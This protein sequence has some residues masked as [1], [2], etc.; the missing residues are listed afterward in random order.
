MTITPLP[1]KQEI[2]SRIARIAHALQENGI[3]AMLLSNFANLYYTT[4]RVFCGYIYITAKGTATHFVRRPVDLEG[5]N[6]QYIRK[7]EQ[8][9]ELLGSEMPSTVALELGL[10]SYNTIERL[11]N[12][13]AGAKVVDATPVINR[14]RA[15]KSEFEIEKLRTCG[16]HHVMAYS[17]IPKVYRSGMTDLELQI[18]VERVLRSEG[19][20]GQF[21]T[22]GD[23][24]EIF[25]GSIL[26][27]RN[28][29]T[30]T[31]YDFALG[32][33][34]LDESLPV[35]CNGSLITP[36]STVMVDMGGDFNGYMTDLTRVYRVGTIS[37]LAEHAHQVSIDIHRRLVAMAR[38][39]VEA[40]FLY[41][42]AVK[43]VT[44]EGLDD[45]F[46][47]TKQKA[48]FIGHGIGIE[49][50][51]LPVL[52]PR[53]H[54]KLVEG[55]VIAIEPKFVIPGVGGVGIENTYVVRPDGLECLTNAP[56]EIIE[57]Y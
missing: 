35:G 32:G 4:G 24:M 12:V 7:P 36:G 23:S 37:P 51:E 18:E 50:S 52:T 28:A 11:R 22:P 54:D 26:C 45:Y 42:E 33:S 34:G 16:I 25:M 57:L 3:D 56:E 29:E 31:P 5:D 55:N 13:F 46:M 15:V 30:P 17:R 44:A 39:G 27:G 47:G 19:S 48:H 20:L 10:S 40:K 43:M 49:I 21:R 2:D 14:L 8:I 38:P 53:N 6:L 1:L 41:E 9:A